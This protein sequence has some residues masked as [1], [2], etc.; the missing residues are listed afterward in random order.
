MAAAVADFRPAQTAQE[1]IKKG[2]SGI[3]L[4][5]ARTT[6]ILAGIGA[7]KQRTG[8][9]RVLVGFAAE[10]EDLI[11]NAG[12]KLESKSL[13]LIAANDISATDAGFGV[14]TNR[15][16]LLFAGGRKEELPLTSKAEVA[17]RILAA[18][19]ELLGEE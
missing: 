18:V 13:D 12:K 15:V 7:E 5:L 2:A 1:K 10:S 4:E 11:A 3:A 9:P 16:T 19:A 6:D 17:A 8:F 14:D